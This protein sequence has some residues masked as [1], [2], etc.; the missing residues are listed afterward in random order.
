LRSATLSILLLAVL[1]M[2]GAPAVHATSLSIYG[3]EDQAQQHCPHDTIVWLN[4]PA[5]VYYQK[6]QRPYGHGQHSAYACKAEA[7]GAGARNSLN[8]S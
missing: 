6:G 5:R 3:S 2:T 4:L 1:L 7:D 8:G